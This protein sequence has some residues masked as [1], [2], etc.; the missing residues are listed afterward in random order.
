MAS[1][2]VI[3]IGGYVMKHTLAYIPTGIK[4]ELVK[5]YVDCDLKG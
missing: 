1:G 5:C 2:D 4:G 3:S